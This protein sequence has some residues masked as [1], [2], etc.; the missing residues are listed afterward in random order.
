[1]TRLLGYWFTALCLVFAFLSAPVRA[2]NEGQG[3]L[4]KA[5]QLKVA[6][7]TLPEVT[8]VIRLTESAHQQGPGQGQ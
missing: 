5:L 6:A 2:E 7:N 3:D 4:D 8:E 1:M